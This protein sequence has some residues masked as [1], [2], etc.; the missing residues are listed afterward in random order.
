MMLSDDKVRDTLDNDARS[1]SSREVDVLATGTHV[2]VFRVGGTGVSVY[3]CVPN[4]C[5]QDT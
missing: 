3:T 2:G 5:G 4:T 1:T